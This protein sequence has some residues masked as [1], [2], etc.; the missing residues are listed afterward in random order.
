MG[1]H[2]VTCHPAEV[3]FPPLP[4]GTPL[5]IILLSGPMRPKKYSEVGSTHFIASAAGRLTPSYATDNADEG[6]RRGQ[7]WS[8]R[9]QRQSQEK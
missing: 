8:G 6:G 7:F 3:T 4:L 5:H 1:S 9:G 2:S